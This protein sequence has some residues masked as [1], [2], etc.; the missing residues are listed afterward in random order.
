ME[1]IGDDEVTKEFGISIREARIK[2]GLHQ[3]DVAE[4]LGM[5]KAYYCYIEAGK[6]N[7]YFTTAVKICRIL[8][9]DIK[10]LEKLLK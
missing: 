5:S 2:K 6:R 9:I 3:A 4:Q 8:D 10:A 1:I 7:I